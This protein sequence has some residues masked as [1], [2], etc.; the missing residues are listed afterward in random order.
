MSAATGGYALQRDGL[1]PVEGV[2]GVVVL[3]TAQGHKQAVSTEFNVLGHELGVHADEC[4]RQSLAHELLL[5]VDTLDHDLSQ[6][7]WF[8]LAVQVPAVIEVATL[9]LTS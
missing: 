3:L 6:P 2:L 4:H 9:V 7:I 1:H 8:Q 5:D